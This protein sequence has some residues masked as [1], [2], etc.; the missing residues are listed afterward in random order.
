MPPMRDDLIALF[1]RAELK[2]YLTDEELAA[3]PAE[4]PLRVSRSEETH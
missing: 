3:M 2:K 1:D 4:A